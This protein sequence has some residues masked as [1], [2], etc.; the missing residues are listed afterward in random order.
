MM[1]NTKDGNPLPLRLDRSGNLGISVALVS[2]NVAAAAADTVKSTET[3]IKQDDTRKTARE[4]RKSPE[5]PKER[6]IVR[7]RE[8]NERRREESKHVDTRPSQPPVRDWDRN[9]VRASV[10][11]DRE[12]SHRR[13]RSSERGR[14]DSRDDEVKRRR[15]S[16]VENEK[17]VVNVQKGL[18]MQHNFIFFISMLDLFCVF[19]LSCTSYFDD[20]TNYETNYSYI[21]DQRIPLRNCWMTYSVRPRPLLAYTGCP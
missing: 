10:E 16:D 8:E 5:R 11:R 18:L 13:R 21:F 9:K 12:R 14:R 7:R 15:R 2:A 20:M 17:P 1:R 4:V 3:T 19:S 6:D